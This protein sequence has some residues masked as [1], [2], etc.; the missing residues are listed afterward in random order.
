MLVVEMRGIVGELEFDASHL[1]RPLHNWPHL[2][3]AVEELEGRSLCAGGV[4]KSCDGRRAIFAGVGKEAE[5][6]DARAK[7]GARV[8]G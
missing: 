3:L 5:H 6:G 1:A 2:G 7:R 8:R 4:E